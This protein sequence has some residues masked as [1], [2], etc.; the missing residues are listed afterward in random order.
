MKFKY[1]L[2]SN[3]TNI[4]II[5]Y[6]ISYITNKIKCDIEDSKTPKQDKNQSTNAC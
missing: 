6:I 3:L 4:P 2:Q 1:S 5:N